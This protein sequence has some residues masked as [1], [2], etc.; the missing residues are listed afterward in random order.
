MSN[1]N[2]EKFTMMKPSSII[3]DTIYE[4]TEPYH[5]SESINPH[6]SNEG[7]KETCHYNCVTVTNLETMF[8]V[9]M[10]GE[11]SFTKTCVDTC[12]RHQSLEA[13]VFESETQQISESGNVVGCMNR[14][15][16]A[17]FIDTSFSQIQQKGDRWKTTDRDSAS[18]LQEKRVANDVGFGLPCKTPNNYFI[19]ASSGWSFTD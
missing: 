11:S 18:Y 16:P 15:A 17:T 6:A 12:D 10:T 9:G 3:T 7:K 14:I 4:S 13:A 19:V 8:P 1:F 5:T 2:N